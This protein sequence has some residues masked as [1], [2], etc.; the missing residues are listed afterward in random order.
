VR[1]DLVG[2]IDL[3]NADAR[4][5]MLCALL[6]LCDTGIVLV[7]CEQLSLLGSDGITMM[8]RVH[9]HATARGADV[10][11]TGLSERHRRVLRLAGMDRELEVAGS[12]R[13]RSLSPPGSP[14]R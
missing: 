5:D 9:R 8:R 2:D 4:G 13:A 12:E 6:D 1:A 11:W 14:P 3:A 7:Q 10:V